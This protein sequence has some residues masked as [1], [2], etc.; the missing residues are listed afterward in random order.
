MMTSA[1]AVAL[2]LSGR[3]GALSR[4]RGRRP[5]GC[6]G[7]PARADSDA[8]LDVVGVWAGGARVR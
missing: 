2:G 6:P 5:A 3:K 7:R 8:L 1:G 4:W